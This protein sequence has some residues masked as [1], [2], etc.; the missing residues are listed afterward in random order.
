M[1]NTIVR[2]SRIT[3]RIPNMA[4]I[5][6]PTLI[7]SSHFGPVVQQDTLCTLVAHNE[8]GFQYTTA[9]LLDAMWCSHDLMNC[10]SGYQYPCPIDE[11]AHVWFVFAHNEQG[12]VVIPPANCQVDFYAVDVWNNIHSGT[13]AGPADFNADGIINSTDFFDFSS[14]FFSTGYDYDRSGTYDSN[15]YFTFITD[16]VPAE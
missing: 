3:P 8:Q 1:Y 12:D 14:A 9:E 11:C 15:D 16:F 2:K 5:V 4:N 6:I 7:L 13:W 10:V